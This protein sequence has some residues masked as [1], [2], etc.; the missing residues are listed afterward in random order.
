M[1]LIDLDEVCPSH[2]GRTPRRFRSLD[3]D[4]DGAALLQPEALPLGGGGVCI[5]SMVFW[6]YCF[7]RRC[8]G[9]AGRE[10]VAD[11]VHREGSRLMV[12]GS[13]AATQ[14]PGSSGDAAA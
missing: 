1:S 9:R 4:D 7:W 5:R 3:L 2:Q 14:A 6:T 10:G 8:M 12:P 13:G 11:T